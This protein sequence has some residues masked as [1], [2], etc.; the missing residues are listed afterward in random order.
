MKNWFLSIVFL[1]C[2]CISLAGNAQIINAGTDSVI[3]KKGTLMVGKLVTP[4]SSKYAK[5]GD[6]IVFKIAENFVIDH[7][8]IITKGTTGRAKVTQAQKA[9]YFGAGGTI[10]IKPEAIYTANGVEIPLTFETAK[11]SSVDN[12]AN[13]AAAIIGVGVFAAFF[14]GANQKI[15]VGSKFKIAVAEDVDLNIKRADLAKSFY[16]LQQT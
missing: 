12:D 3:I 5:V 15:P 11:I 9:G 1:L 8:I 4:V 6:S 10:G 2:C 16:I 14:H 7:A 13:M